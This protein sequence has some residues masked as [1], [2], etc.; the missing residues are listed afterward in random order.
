MRQRASL[1]ILP[2]LLLSALSLS[3]GQSSDPTQTRLATS[4]RLVAL[5][6]SDFDTLSSRAESG[7]RGDPSFTV[8]NFMPE[9]WM[10]W[11]AAKDQPIDRQAQLWQDYYVRPHQAVFND[12]AQPCKD[13]FDSEW[14]RARYLI[15][16]RRYSSLA[17]AYARVTAAGKQGYRHLRFRVLDKKVLRF[18]YSSPKMRFE[19]VRVCTGSG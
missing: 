4:A 11:A 6:R 9:F 15:A 1:I 18:Y 13:E 14:A 16:V 12:L 3:A 8:H 2:L 5:T 7:D 17:F 19:G 10:F